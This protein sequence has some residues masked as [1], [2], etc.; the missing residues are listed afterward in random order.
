MQAKVC[1]LEG[2]GNTAS[3]GEALSGAPVRFIY[4][5]AEKRSPHALAHFQICS[6]L[7]ALSRLV[8]LAVCSWMGIVRACKCWSLRCLLA[9]FPT[10]QKDF[11]FNPVNICTVERATKRD[12][13]IPPTANTAIFH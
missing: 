10:S 9:C 7:F 4:R 5:S 8:C 13:F 3:V 6:C 1:L 11:K 2:A 12:N